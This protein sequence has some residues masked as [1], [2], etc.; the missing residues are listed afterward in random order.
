MRGYFIGSNKTERLKGVFNKAAG[1][2][3]FSKES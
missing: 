2:A 3:V 1:G